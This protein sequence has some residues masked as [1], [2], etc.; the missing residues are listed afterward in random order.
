[1][2]LW[3][4]GFWREDVDADGGFVAASV[5]AQAAGGRGL[6][7]DCSSDGSD[8]VDYGVGDYACGSDAEGETDT[9]TGITLG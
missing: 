1:M 9:E 6:V 3:A 4:D 5:D 8:E 2:K 7:Q